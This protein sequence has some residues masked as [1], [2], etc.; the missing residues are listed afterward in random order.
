MLL[1]I[2]FSSASFISLKNAVALTSFRSLLGI[3]VTCALRY[4]FI[5]LRSWEGS[6]WFKAALVFLGCGVISFADSGLAWL[7]I[8]AAGIEQEESLEYFLKSSILMRWMFYWLWSVLYFSISYWLD[9]EHARLR[10]AQAEA[11]ARAS[12][13][14]VLRAQV[15]PHFLF[16]ALN[17]ILAESENPASVRALTQALSD[18]LRFSLQQRG[19]LHPLGIELDALENYLCVEK[20]RF[21]ENLEYQ[22]D[23]SPAARRTPIPI[24]LVQTLLDNA[25]KYGQRSTIRPLR[26]LISAVE[27]GGLL[28]VTVANTGE[29]IVAPSSTGTGLAN[30]CRRLHLLYGEAASLATEPLGSEVR[31]HV[32]LP[33]AEKRGGAR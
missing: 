28:R 29:W 19:D 21:E 26:V 10:V 6:L 23:A 18:Y 24:A 13:L 9:T 17:S 2:V 31:V 4:V 22:I 25:I 1:G 11:V 32:R 8:N 3:A 14:Q 7:M 20:A 15:N 30:L 27:E 16:N 33:L 12:E 5:R